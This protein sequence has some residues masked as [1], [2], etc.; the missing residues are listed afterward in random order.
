MNDK[1]SVIVPLYN[2]AELVGKCLDS[3][4]AQTYQNIEYIVVDDG[5]Q[6]DSGKIADKYAMDDPRFKIIHHEVNKGIA[7]GF[8]T[9]IK[10]STGKYVT[11]V[12]SDNYIS[13]VMIERLVEL[14]EK[15][16]ADVAQGEALCYTD[17]REIKDYPKKE[18]EIIVLENKRDIQEDFL[19]KRHIT[20]NLSVK[21]FN[22]AWFDDIE[23]PEGRQVV[24]TTTML[25]M[26]GKSERYVCTNEFL[27]YAYMPA[28]S[29]SRGEVTERRISDTIY[30]NDFYCRYINKYWPEFSDYSTYRTVSTAIW[31]YMKVKKSKKI[32]FE[33]K[34]ELLRKFRSDFVNNYLESKETLYYGTMSGTTKIVWALYYRLPLLYN[35]ICRFRG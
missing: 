11:F 22:R 20:N 35:L 18:V 9:G 29:I 19:F 25:Q 1:V 5:S 33:K 16:Q 32:D 7:C 12:D 23:I 13:E 17:E 8:I 34:K 30:A 27:Y 15:Y 6:D 31:A 24:D 10:N 2:M 14:K 21:L 3:L 28:D 26:V 4:K